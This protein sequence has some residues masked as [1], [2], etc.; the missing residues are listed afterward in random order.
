[1]AIETFRFLIGLNSSR[2]LKILEASVSSNDGKHIDVTQM[3]NALV[4]RGSTLFI[5]D[6]QQDLKLEFFEGHLTLTYRFDND[7]SE[8]IEVPFYSHSELLVCDA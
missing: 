6:F 8:L 7:K 2:V 4:K 5:L 3:M 1:M